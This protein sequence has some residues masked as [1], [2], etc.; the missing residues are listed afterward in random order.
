MGY[1]QSTN[2]IQSQ[3][4]SAYN[5]ACGIPLIISQQ[6]QQFKTI[7]DY[8]ESVRR[9]NELA[10]RHEICKDFIDRLRNLDGI[11]I[12]IIADDSGSMGSF[13]SSTSEKVSSNRCTR[14]MELQEFINTAIDMVSTIYNDGCNV[15]FL[16]REP[17]LNVTKKNNYIQHFYHHHPVEHP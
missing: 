2:N 4:I 6:H 3:Q 15:Y 9:F 10:Q 14:W 1:Q 17:I 7:A 5:P 8:E 11:E 16:N 13:V 12:V